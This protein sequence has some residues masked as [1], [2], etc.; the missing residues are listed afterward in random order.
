MSGKGECIAFANHKGGTAKTTTCLSIAGYL[1]RKGYK[2]LVVDFDPQ[3]NATSGLGIDGMS[4]RHSMYDVV[5]D[6]CHGQQGTPITQ[7]ILETDV[8]N[9]HVAPS[10]LDLAVAETV[11]QR[12][13][14]R[15]SILRRALEKIKPRYDFLLIDLPPSSGLLTI[16][17]LCAADQVIV[18]IDPSIF[19]LEAIENLRRSFH[20]IRRM[21]HHTIRRITAVLVRYKRPN[22]LSRF[23]GNRNSCQ[24]IETRLKEMFD[25]VFVV[26]ESDEI[27]RAQK[28]G[29]PVSHL[30]PRSSVGKAYGKIAESIAE[31]Q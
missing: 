19:A 13:G 31:Q 11:M 17:G 30:A 20:D 3:A 18:P 16:N 23:M 8:E 28:K 4:L 1:A 5:L 6:L 21:T 2:V 10:E 15:W 27:Y 29:I 14:N 22:L 26:P 25:R 24:E 9:L 7:V 12:T